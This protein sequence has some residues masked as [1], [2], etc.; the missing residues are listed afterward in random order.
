[1]QTELDNEAAV[2]SVASKSIQSSIGSKESPQLHLNKNLSKSQACFH[3]APHG[4]SHDNVLGPRHEDNANTSEDQ[5]LNKAEITNVS[6]LIMSEDQ[7]GKN[8]SKPFPNSSVTE[9]PSC[10]QTAEAKDRIRDQVQHVSEGAEDAAR[11]ARGSNTSTDNTEER[12]DGRVNKRSE[13]GT[14]SQSLSNQAPTG[15][16]PTKH[17]HDVG[18]NTDSHTGLCPDTEHHPHEEANRQDSPASGSGNSK[19][20][21]ADQPEQAKASGRHKAGDAKTEQKPA[22]QVT[23]ATPRKRSRTEGRPITS[24]GISLEESQAT[25]EAKGKTSRAKA[26][27]KHERVGDIGTPTGHKLDATSTIMPNSEE[28]RVAEEKAKRQ[29][30]AVEYFLAK[31][32]RR[33]GTPSST[34]SSKQKSSNSKLA[35][36]S[37]VTDASVQRLRKPTVANSERSSSPSV[38]SDSAGKRRS[39]TP[40]FPS[41]IRPT[42]SAL[43]TSS[44]STRRSVSFNDDPIAPPGLLSTASSKLPRSKLRNTN[45]ALEPVAESKDSKSHSPRSQVSHSKPSNEPTPVKKKLPASEPTSRTIVGR[46]AATP[47]QKPKVQSKLTITRD[48]KL[49][50]RAEGPAEPPTPLKHKEDVISS[51]SENSASTF[52]SDEEDQPR[53]AKAGPS[54]KRKLTRA[55]KPAAAASTIELDKQQQPLVAMPRVE[56]KPSVTS[57]EVTTVSLGEGTMQRSSS[58]S[59]HPITPNDGADNDIASRETSTSRSP[60]QYVSKASSVSSSSRSDSRS[61][62]VSRG[63]DGSESE[64][65]SEYETGSDSEDDSESV[66][67]SGSSS[68]SSAKPPT[69]R[70]DRKNPTSVVSEAKSSEKLLNRRSQSRSVSNSSLVHSKDEDEEQIAKEINHQLQEYRQS[71]QMAP[72]K[73]P[74]KSVPRTGKPITSPALV[75][76]STN[77]R[78]PSLTGLRDKVSESGVSAVTTTPLPT[79]PASSKVGSKAAGQK[80]TTKKDEVSSSSSESE[81]SSSS[82]DDQDDGLSQKSVPKTPTPQSG[83][84][85]GLRS[86]V[87]RMFLYGALDP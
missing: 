58:P 35:T 60:A 16:G 63:D 44:S 41:L 21:E 62:V 80:Q 8:P 75:K 32:S 66:A 78:F 29:A 7:R 28:K 43:R 3:I 65:G 19:P 67:E 13:P 61:F 38:K 74:E 76:K 40:L 1:M 77:S 9:P 14:G 6:D 2:S 47:G 52:Y 50:G 25:S 53:S 83:P 48:V 23:V 12:D 57:K 49:K 33:Q 24:A 15:T 34:K 36:E 42:K 20:I 72:P 71:I 5:S 86:L 70:P 54:K 11:L 22:T 64:S 27:A 56:G 68:G 39:M 18:I 82:S 10:L 85:K 84:I 45:D 31:D 17:K 4:A 46:K 30:D 79:A 26:A 55:T 73:P 51:D 87:K 59:H 69:S 37:L 81:D